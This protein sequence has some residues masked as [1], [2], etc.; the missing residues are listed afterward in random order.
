MY[1]LNQF[2]RREHRSTAVAL[3]YVPLQIQ[4]K[5]MYWYSFSVQDT[6]N[7]DSVPVNIVVI[8]PAI[9]PQSLYH[10]Y[11]PLFQQQSLPFIRITVT[12][13]FSST[14]LPV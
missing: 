8:V 7:F 3:I 10:D 6:Q 2:M 5:M 1:R 4:L 13:Y 14:F 12:I 9:F 11:L